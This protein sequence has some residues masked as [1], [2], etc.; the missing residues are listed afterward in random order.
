MPDRPPL[1][2]ALG[3]LKAELESSGH[4]L[5]HLTTRDAWLAFLRFGQRRFDTASSP[6]SDGLLFQYGTYRFSG[7]PMFTLDLTRQFDISHEGGE[8][9]HYVQIHCELLYAPDQRLRDLGCFTG[10]FFHDSDN[11]IDRWAEALN[12]HL[13]PLSGHRPT[14]INVYEERV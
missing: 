4:A 12:G 7:P 2:D 1:A 5:T 10:W 14:E 3:S 11:H 13:E 6:N 8:H 9:D